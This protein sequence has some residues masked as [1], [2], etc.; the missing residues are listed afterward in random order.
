MGFDEA[1]PA[2]RDKQVGV[3]GAV[4][5]IAGRS[6]AAIVVAGEERTPRERHV[7][8]LL[9][10]QVGSLLVAEG[11]RGEEV[12]KASPE[13]CPTKRQPGAKAPQQR[14]F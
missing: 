11:G 9:L 1:C 12:G 8:M 14:R 10:I 7:Q 3:C 5:P 4:Q 13:E 2:E 6:G